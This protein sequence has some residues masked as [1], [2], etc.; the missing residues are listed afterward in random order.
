MRGRVAFAPAS[1]RLSTSAVT[2]RLSHFCTFLFVINLCGCGAEVACDFIEVP[3]AAEG[4]TTST[5]SVE[6][7]CQQRFELSAKPDDFSTFE[8]I[9]SS[10]EKKGYKQCPAG[11]RRW[12]RYTS[13]QS[14]FEFSG[15]RVLVYFHSMPLDSIVLVAGFQ[16]GCDSDQCEQVFLVQRTSNLQPDPESL[17]VLSEICFGSRDQVRRFHV[18]SG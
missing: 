1:H 13:T 5:E 4:F 15:E 7:S 9:T 6:N 17:G 2:R 10:I 8:R 14:N 16:S 18:P 12:E 3:D 11:V